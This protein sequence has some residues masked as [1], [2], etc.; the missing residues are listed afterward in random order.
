MATMQMQVRLNHTTKRRRRNACSQRD[1]DFPV[2]ERV[3]FLEMS[4]GSIS[5]SLSSAE[6]PRS[7]RTCVYGSPEL[8]NIV[9]RALL[10]KP[11]KMEISA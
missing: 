9:P 11:P 2:G 10:T 1:G 6:P 8:D 3:K 4:L 7:L 5:I